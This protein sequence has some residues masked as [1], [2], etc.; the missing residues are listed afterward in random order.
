LK[1]RTHSQ[2]GGT[3]KLHLGHGTDTVKGID[4]M[5][6]HGIRRWLIIASLTITTAEFVFFLI[7]PMAGYPLTFAQAI[8]LLEIVLPV[9]LGYLGS[10]ARFVFPQTSAPDPIRR[11]A[12]S[13]ASLLVRGPIIVFSLAS[14]AALIAFGHS[15]RIDA[16]VGAGMDIDTLAGIL[17]VALGL[18]A[19][20]T[21]VAVSYFFP[22]VG[23]NYE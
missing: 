5:N 21:N 14:I 4:V 13:L 9:F 10:A 1:S 18:L 3:D 23:S 12:P 11:A 15:N 20:T 22:H 8:R 6:T 17:S 16:P 2:K 19:V 7:A